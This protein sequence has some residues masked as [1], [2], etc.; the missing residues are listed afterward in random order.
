[1]L[2]LL[3]YI[4]HRIIHGGYTEVRVTNFNKQTV[5]GYNFCDKKLNK[6]FKEIK[7]DSK[8]YFREDRSE[9]MSEQAA[10]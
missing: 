4:K 2:G 10:Q 5:V 8:S 6:R 7:D 9:K 1:M 3:R